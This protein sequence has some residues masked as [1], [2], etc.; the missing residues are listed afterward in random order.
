MKRWKECILILSLLP[1]KSAFADT[2]TNVPVADSGIEQHSPDL[3]VGSATRVVSGELG[4]RAGGEI[5]RALFQFD[6]H[7][8]PP[9]SIIN[10]VTLRVTTV[11][12]IPSSPANSNFDLRRVLQPWVENEVTWK[13]RLS[14]AP[15]QMPGASSPSDSAG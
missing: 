9:G 5:R 3:N 1:L 14:G 6:L 15:W 8:I 7:Q 11:F 13:S 12:L 4:F 10:S 2:I